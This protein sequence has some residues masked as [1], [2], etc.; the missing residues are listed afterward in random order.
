MHIPCLRATCRAQYES[1]RSRRPAT[2]VVSVKSGSARP[3]KVGP[4][5]TRHSDGATCL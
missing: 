5:V 1:K 3:R 2:A 4:S